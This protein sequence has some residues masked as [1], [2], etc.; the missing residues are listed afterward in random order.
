MAESNIRYLRQL[1][2]DQLNVGKYENVEE[3]WRKGFYLSSYVLAFILFEI[4]SDVQDV[5]RICDEGKLM[6]TPCSENDILGELIKEVS[7]KYI[8][9]ID[10]S[11][12]E[13]FFKTDNLQKVRN[14]IKIL[15]QPPSL[16]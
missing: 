14:P 9:S 13:E 3:K 7:K 4:N 12:F 16:R 6:G 8:Q 2:R 11:N 1:C 10:I 15:N 5:L